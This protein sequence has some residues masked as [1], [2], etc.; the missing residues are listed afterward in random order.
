MSNEGFLF[1]N[2]SRHFFIHIFFIS[3][4]QG[5]LKNMFAYKLNSLML[6]F[7]N[8]FKIILSRIFIMFICFCVVY[9]FVNV[10]LQITRFIFI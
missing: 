6:L 1:N 8:G 4:E 5:K 3:T 9:L 10:L 2:I 7:E